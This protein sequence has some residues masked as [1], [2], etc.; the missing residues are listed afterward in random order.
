MGC[1][2]PLERLTYK[3]LLLGSDGVGKTTWVHRLLTGQFNEQY[4]KTEDNQ[5]NQVDLNTYPIQIS[6]Q[7]YDCPST[8]EPSSDWNPDAVIIMY[9]TSYYISYEWIRYWYRQV[10]SVY[11]NIPIIVCGNKIDIRPPFIYS[12]ECKNQILMSV[13]NNINLK[14]PLI[15]LASNLGQHLE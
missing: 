2:Y 1:L 3:V 5:I 11:P 15:T 13:K 8:I 14:A 12:Q 10:E 6:F 9:S 4:I 7:I